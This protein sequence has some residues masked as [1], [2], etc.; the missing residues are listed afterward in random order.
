MTY[1][2]LLEAQGERLLALR[3]GKMENESTQLGSGNEV[4]HKLFDIA[5]VC[6][7]N[8]QICFFFCSQLL[9]GEPVRKDVQ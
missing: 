1:R 5:K 3:E 2:H 8:Q 9:H 6:V 4:Q 7:R